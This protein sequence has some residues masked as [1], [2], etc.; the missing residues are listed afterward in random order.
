M[1][2]PFMMATSEI[3]R[4][5]RRGVTLQ[6]IFYMAI[7]ILPL[8]VSEGLYATFRCVGETEQISK[9]LLEDKAYLESFIEKKLS[10]LK[11]IPN[12]VQYWQQR[13]QDV[14]AMIGQLGKPT[15]MF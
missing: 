14:F 9:G 4:K 3:R 6:H 15:T 1:I 5:D 11:S 10:F 12:S 2:T 8:R 13:K 7:K